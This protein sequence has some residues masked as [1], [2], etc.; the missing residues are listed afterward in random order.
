MNQSFLLLVAVLG[1]VLMLGCGQPKF[2]C[3]LKHGQ[4]EMIPELSDEFDG[5]RLDQTKWHPCNPGWQGRQPGWFSPKNVTVS[6][7]KLHL[8]ARAE[9]LPDLPKGYQTFTTAAVK[10]K[11]RVLH[12]YFEIRCRAM[13]SKASSAFWFYHS[14]PNWWTE[15]D[16]FE[17][18][19]G[20][21]G[22]EQVVH[23]NAHVFVT[24]TEG[25]KHW[26]KGGDYKAPFDPAADY[27]T[28]GLEWNAKEL[29][30]YVDGQVVRTMENTHWHQAL[31]MNFDSETMP[32]WF[33]L[34]DPKTL[35]A[36]FSIEY[37]RSW[38]PVGP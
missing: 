28:Y 19:C 8:T 36:S 31:E 5:D 17:M 6:D 29:R 32:E 34:P 23:M 25:S 12:G 24:P 4:W 38:R 20:A 7:G 22:H 27:H 9:D 33:G 3:P 11:A 10:S 18:G 13:K 2:A 30:Y 35:P 1:A 14:D 26:S 16:V 37:V 15:I 21:T